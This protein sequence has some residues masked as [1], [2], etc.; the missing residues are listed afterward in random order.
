M[1]VRRRNRIFCFA[2][3]GKPETDNRKRIF[4]P[5]CEEYIVGAEK[6]NDTLPFTEMSKGALDKYTKSNTATCT[7][8]VALIGLALDIKLREL[9]EGKYGIMNLMQDLSKTYGKNQSF[10]DEELFDKITELTYP[11]IRDF[12]RQYVEGTN[13]LPLTETFNQ[14]GITY[15]QEGEE[16]KQTLG[17]FTLGYNPKTE[18]LFVADTDKMNAFGRKMGFK[19]GDQLLQING[20]NLTPEN[21]SDLLGTYVQNAPEGSRITVLV[22]RPGATGKM[23]AVKLKGRLQK[24]LEKTENQ[25]V[26]NPDATPKQLEL[27]QAWLYGKL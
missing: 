22:N 8:K 25:L 15:Q 24:T 23:Q 12:F 13:P 3:A 16:R 11:E 20:K 21:A 18:R 4:R 7:R 9:S 6:Y 2:R 5:T 10:K 26:L 1:V 14:V 19:K 17:R 27:R